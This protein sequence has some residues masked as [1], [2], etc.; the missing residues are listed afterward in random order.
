MTKHNTICQSCGIPLKKDPNHGGT[1]TDG[2]TNNEYCGYCYKDGK[3]TFEGNVSDFQ[4]FCKGKM[5][6]DGH[7]KMMAWLFSRGMKR[8]NRWKN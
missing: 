6:E 8:L 7:S 1:N 3:F 4:E 2:T 5:I